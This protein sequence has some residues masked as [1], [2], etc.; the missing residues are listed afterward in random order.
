L[1]FVGYYLSLSTLLSLAGLWLSR[2]TMHDSL[3]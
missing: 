2:E 1:S 3:D